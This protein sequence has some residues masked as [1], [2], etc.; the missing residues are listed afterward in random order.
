M[1]SLGL[2]LS[3]NEYANKPKALHVRLS[4]PEY[5]TL[6]EIARYNN[7]TMSRLARLLLGAGIKRY[8]GAGEEPPGVVLRH[9]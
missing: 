9:M 2:P 6:T 1:D 4:E 5:E 3:I 8:V 7:I